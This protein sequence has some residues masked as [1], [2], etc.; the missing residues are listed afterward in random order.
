MKEY[1]DSSIKYLKEIFEM[2]YIPSRDFSSYKEFFVANCFE[3]AC[4]NLT[5]KQ[6]KSPKLINS[7]FSD[8]YD[9]FST[10]KTEDNMLNLITD[11]GLKI[12]KSNRKTILKN[13]WKISLYFSLNPGYITYIND[14]HFFLQTYNSNIWT[15]KMGFLDNKV[16]T[17]HRLNTNFFHQPYLYQRYA[18]YIITNPNAPEK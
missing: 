4:F 10:E 17:H 12:E 7:F 6:L 2:G 8:F 3:H 13:Q 16:Y 9:K 18:N 1:Y 15:S 5:D 11:T 14:F